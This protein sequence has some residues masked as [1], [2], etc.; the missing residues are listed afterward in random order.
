MPT[1]VTESQLT[2]ELHVRV[3]H[4]ADS[5]AARMWLSIFGWRLGPVELNVVE[6]NRAT[7]LLQELVAVIASAAERGG[8]MAELDN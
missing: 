5:G 3:E 1:R 2:Q 4:E 6:A 7:K 8:V